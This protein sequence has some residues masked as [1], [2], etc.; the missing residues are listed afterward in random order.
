MWCQCF[1]LST[2]TVPQFFSPLRKLNVRETDVILTQFANKYPKAQSEKYEIIWF[3]V[4]GV[5][6]EFLFYLA[7]CSEVSHH[8]GMRIE[9]FDLFL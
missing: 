5:G 3:S 8:V 9:M 4:A 6:G 7:S 2:A 1:G